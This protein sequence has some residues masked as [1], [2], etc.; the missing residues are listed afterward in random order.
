[1]INLNKFIDK[2]NVKNKQNITTNID[3]YENISY[4]KKHDKALKE[5]IQYLSDCNTC[6][7]AKIKT[8][9]DPECYTEEHGYSDTGNL[10]LD[11]CVISCTDENIY[12]SVRED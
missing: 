9:N 11:W 6:I 12:W 7:D 5:V 10:Y 1:M 8:R 3:G 2:D 4:S